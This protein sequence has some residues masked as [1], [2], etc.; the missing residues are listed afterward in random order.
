[1]G[2]YDHYK[3]TVTGSVLI[4]AASGETKLRFEIKGEL[5]KRSYACE[6]V[7]GRAGTKPF[8]AG[9]LDA[10]AFGCRPNRGVTKLDLFQAGPI[11]KLL[12][13]A[14]S[15]IF[16]RPC[17]RWYPKA[18]SSHRPANPE[19]LLVCEIMSGD[20]SVVCLWHSGLATAIQ[21]CDPPTASAQVPSSIAAKKR[22]ERNRPGIFHFIPSCPE[23]LSGQLKRAF[24][25]P[26]NH[27]SARHAVSRQ[28]SRPV[29]YR[30]LGKGSCPPKNVHRGARAV[31]IFC[32]RSAPA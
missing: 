27:A 17:F 13:A 18:A 28:T 6:R 22:S 25:V 15:Y 32:R 21:V 26:A 12:T 10:S 31:R 14:S 1:M 7:T 19:R 5:S 20:P 16:R 23:I 2:R 8:V 11:S 30:N 24:A 9:E 29:K 4:Q 3:I